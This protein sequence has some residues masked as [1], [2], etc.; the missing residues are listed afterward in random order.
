[1]KKISI[2]CIQIMS[3]VITKISI[4]QILLILSLLAL[5][6]CAVHQFI[7][8]IVKVRQFISICFFYAHFSFR[9]NIDSSN[10]CDISDFHRMCWSHLISKLSNMPSVVLRHRTLLHRFNLRALLPRR[11]DF[12]QSAI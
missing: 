2:L 4:L 5:I 8:I 6:T 10:G 1:M 3:N 11:T 7:K 9:S 12:L